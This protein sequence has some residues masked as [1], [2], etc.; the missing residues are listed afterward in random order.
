MSDIRIYLRKKNKKI[1]GAS[2]SKRTLKEGQIDRKR[3]K[4]GKRQWH[5]WLFRQSQ[6][7][8]MNGN[9]GKC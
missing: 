9:S 6:T 3:D 5:V 4:K 7:D 2:S 8:N 1:P